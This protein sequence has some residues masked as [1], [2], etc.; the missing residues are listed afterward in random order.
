MPI[1]PFDDPE[2]LDT[3]NLIRRIDPHQHLV[4][5]HDHQCL[6][7]SSKV[8]TPSSGEGEGMSVDVERLI[9]QDGKSAAEFVTT[10]KYVG[11]VFFTASAARDLRLSVGK[12]P[13]DDNPYH[14]DVWGDKRPNRFTGGQ[15]NGLLK[16]S[17]WFVEIPNVLIPT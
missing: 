13:K 2:I 10:P 3:D 6:R 1:V 15:K 4:P 12:T 8:F 16:S 14:A 5:D 11:S 7:V 17:S 9:E